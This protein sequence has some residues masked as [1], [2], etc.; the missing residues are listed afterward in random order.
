[1]MQ[2]ARAVRLLATLQ[3]ELEYAAVE[4]RRAARRAAL[5]ARDPAA[6]A[7]LGPLVLR[8]SEAIEVDA[9]HAAVW[10]AAE[11]FGYVVAAQRYAE[12]L[13]DDVRRR[14]DID[15]LMLV[16]PLLSVAHFES[17]V[18]PFSG[19]RRLLCVCRSAAQ[20][21]RYRL[22]LAG[23]AIVDG[24]GEGKPENA[25]C[26]APFAL[27]RVLQ[28]ID[29]NQSFELEE[30]L[31]L[32]NALLTL[33]TSSRVL[34]PSGRPVVVVGLRE[35][36]FTQCL[37]A[38][39]YFMA[40]QEYL[41]G[42]MWQR[43]M[44][45]PLDVRMHYGHP[46]IFD[47][48]WA[49]SRG[50]TAKASV[51]VNVSEDIFAG[52]NT[53]LR[54]GESRH[55]EFMQVGKGR[56]V[57]I[58]QIEIFESKISG[59]TAISATTRDS[60]RLCE[61]MDTAR[62]LSFYHTSSGF[63]VSNVLVV[64]S[65]V[66]TIYYFAA[67]ALTGAD[68]AILA[69]RLVYLVGDINIA[70]WC[71]QLGLLSALPLLALHALEAGLP[72][73]LYRTFKMMFAMGGPLFYMFEIATKAYFFDA[74]LTFGRQGYLATGRDFVIRHVPF[75]ETFR[76]TAHSHLYLGAEMAFLLS[77]L[78]AYG[79]FESVRVYIFF[80]LT[81]WLFSF[82][83][84]FG[85]LWFNPLAM[86][87]RAVLDDWRE[88]WLWMMASGKAKAGAAAGG[89]SAEESWR[90]WY[91]KE[92][93]SQCSSTA[94]EVAR[95]PDR[96]DQRWLRLTADT[97]CRPTAHPPPCIPHLPRSHTDEHA[98]PMARIVRLVRISRLLLPAS[99]L[100]F[101]LRASRGTETLA[102]A[103]FGAAPF[104]CIADRKSVV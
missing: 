26:A 13:E 83:L 74:A 23:N 80:F 44:A 5:A 73:A 102:L 31:K 85:A 95:C 19:Q 40:Q 66:A 2:S 3:L 71:V 82:S 87:W 58:L 63:Y 94:R 61:G 104:A 7:A 12:H 49:A 18:S 84:L 79:V 4:E 64:V 67:V 76:A 21:V 20:G 34:A 103:V 56:D 98:S 16:H 100:V 52:F 29:M 59:G 33:S 32:P 41:F 22:P 93:G 50:G 92:T 1:M 8:S 55:C 17:S 36:I 69:S 86:E 78:T 68:F 54:G 48:V 24:I 90:A 57:G 72:I 6:A 38:P 47:K 9:A 91:D 46:D 101:G 88:W 60:F 37:S 15:L 65:L 45:S 99:I 51:G 28:C 53:M 97:Q 96:R 42:V 11:R 89:A 81:A 25:N 35:H 43:L 77:L 70:Q 30:A 39:A 75:P 62:L 27:G 10:F 14:A